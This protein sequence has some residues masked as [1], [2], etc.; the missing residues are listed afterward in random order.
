MVMCTVRVSFQ[1][2]ALWYGFPVVL[3]QTIVVSLWLVMP[4]AEMSEESKPHF[5]MTVDM[6][7]TQFFQISSGSCSTCPADGYICV[8]S[9]W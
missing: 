1:T 2:I 3:S 7:V 5:S 6:Q 9:S 8:C 4:M